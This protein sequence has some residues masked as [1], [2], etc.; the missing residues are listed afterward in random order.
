M[1]GADDR[2]VTL[3]ERREAGLVEHVG[4]PG[5]DVRLRRD[6]FGMP[7]DRCHMMP[8]TEKFSQKTRSG[9]AGC[10]DEH[11]FHVPLLY[12]I[13]WILDTDRISPMLRSEPAVKKAPSRHL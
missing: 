10:A 9:L 1:H 8:A 13:R 4:F 12:G 5:D 11:D 7:G 3:D 2:V 6:L